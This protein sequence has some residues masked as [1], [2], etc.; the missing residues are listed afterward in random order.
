MLRVEDVQEKSGKRTPG[1]GPFL[2]RERMKSVNYVRNTE[3]DEELETNQE[4]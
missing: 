4:V 3:C 2:R 1:L